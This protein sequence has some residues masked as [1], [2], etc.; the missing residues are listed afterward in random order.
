[1]ALLHLAVSQSTIRVLVS[2]RAGEELPRGLVGLWKDE[3]LARLD[4]APLSRDAT[5]ELVL[6]VLGEGVP[7]SLLDRIWRL[8]RGN[9]L[10][11][12]E[13]VT[14]ALERRAAVLVSVRGAASC[15][16]RARRSA[17]AAAEARRVDELMARCDGPWSPALA[18]PAPVG[19]DLTERERE[20]ALLA[21]AGR[22]SP[23]IAEALY[24]SVRT[25]DTHLHRVY[26][27]LMIEGR[28]Q[29]AEAL[30]TLT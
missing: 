29:L 25:V 15:C 24:L 16:P 13:L 14:A 17:S 6:A 20:V 8:S 21:A 27:K 11:V 5:E 23:E 10:F 22:T 26:R 7:T 18:A 2:V 28:R 4:V 1:V 12:R 9:A 30:G 19:A 3:L